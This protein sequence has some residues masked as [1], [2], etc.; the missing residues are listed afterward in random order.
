M[1]KAKKVEVRDIVY[2]SVAS[3]IMQDSDLKVLQRHKEG[4]VI[5][6]NGKTVILRAIEKKK[7]LEKSEFRGEYRFNETDSTF[8]YVPVKS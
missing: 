5:N 6:A 3:A 2:Q 4:L 8:E 7:D 1:T